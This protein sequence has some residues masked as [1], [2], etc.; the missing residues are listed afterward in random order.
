MFAAASATAQEAYSISASAQNVTDLTSVVA[1]KNVKTCLRLG[2]VAACTQAQACTAAS[3]AGGASCT[4]SQA[5]AVN[6]R[7]F[8]ATLAGR[9]EYTAFQIVLPAFLDQLAAVPGQAQKQACL[10]WQG[11]NTTQKNTACTAFGLPN[12]CALY[13]SSC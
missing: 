7:I 1:A 4:A 2:Q 10:A 11:Y 13:G 5:R 3:A 12:G 6:A 8:P 9:E